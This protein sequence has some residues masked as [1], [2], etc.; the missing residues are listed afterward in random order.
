MFCAAAFIKVQ[1]AHFPGVRIS[2]SDS[3]AGRVLR[4]LPSIAQ[5]VSRFHDG[6]AFVVGLRA[7]P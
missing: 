7:W 2:M 4:L 5:R 6:A 3:A 1:P